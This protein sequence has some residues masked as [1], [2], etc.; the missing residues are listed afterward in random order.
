M[1][2]W[3]ETSPRDVSPVGCPSGQKAFSP[4]T[5]LNN[6]YK[7][8]QFFCVLQYTSTRG[9]STPRLRINCKRLEKVQQT[10]GVTFFTAKRMLYLS[11]LLIT[12]T[13]FCS[14]SAC[15]MADLV[16]VDAVAVSARHGTS[17]NDRS[18]PTKPHHN[19]N[20]CSFSSSLC[21]TPAPP[22]AR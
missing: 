16:D 3:S 4:K 22:I 13:A 7:D 12:V 21:G 15:E 9:H 20:G 11:W 1:E 19:R 14:P 2:C 8:A 17:N 10:S 5:R 6:R 18:S